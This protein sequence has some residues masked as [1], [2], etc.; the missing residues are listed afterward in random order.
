MA[1]AGTGQNSA[2]LPQ[3]PCKAE[4]KRSAAPADTAP[5][6]PKPPARA[7]AVVLSDASQ[8]ILGLIAAH[9]GR[10][11]SDILAELV[12]AAGN[13]I[14]LSPLLARAAGEIGDLAGLPDY[15]R[16]AASRYRSGVP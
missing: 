7:G 2:V 15:A 9:Q 1:E 3:E 14:G 12:A 8:F 6:Y 10:P 5:A 13:E 16:R 4:I 11:A